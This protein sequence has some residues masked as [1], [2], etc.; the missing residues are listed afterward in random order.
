[1]NI[2]CWCDLMSVQDWCV[3]V[4]LKKLTNYEDPGHRPVKSP[5]WSFVLACFESSLGCSVSLC[6]HVCL[7]YLALFG[8]W[9]LAP[10]AMRMETHSVNSQSW[11]RA[12]NTSGS[13]CTQFIFHLLNHQWAT[14]A[15]PCSDVHL[16]N[17]LYTTCMFTGFPLSMFHTIQTVRKGSKYNH[18]LYITSM[19][20]Y[21][22]QLLLAC[23]V[24]LKGELYI[25]IF[26][27][28]SKIDNNFALM[29]H[30]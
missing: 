16:L 30:S 7:C 12:G 24:T 29:Y 22:G 28:I 25:K 19:L 11:Y 10:W 6:R 26:P 20:E 27:C 23:E 14:R 18:I 5:F 8:Y 2:H 4:I 15:P 1:M 13:G 21:L 9:T 17:L 3:K